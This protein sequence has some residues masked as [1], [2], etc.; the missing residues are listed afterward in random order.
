MTYAKQNTI[1][2]LFYGMAN[3]D[4]SLLY[5]SSGT[6]LAANGLVLDN[7]TTVSPLSVLGAVSSHNFLAGLYAMPQ[8]TGEY[9]APYE[10][11]IYEQP[12]SLVAAIPER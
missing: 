8:D 12:S 10:A 1:D 11:A 7:G 6:V 3:L 4:T 5:A 2:A 9:Y